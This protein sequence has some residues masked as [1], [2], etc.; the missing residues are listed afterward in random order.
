[1]Y[2]FVFKEEQ[3][4]EEFGHEIKNLCSSC[5]HLNRNSPTRCAAFP[6]GIPLVILLGKFDH[7][8]EFNFKDISDQGITYTEDI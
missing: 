1:M 5:L 2:S 3:V 6:E 4:P 8:V 7:T